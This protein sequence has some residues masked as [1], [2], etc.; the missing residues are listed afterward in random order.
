MVQ[1]N[2]FAISREFTDTVLGNF[3][4]FYEQ[5]LYKGIDKKD[6]IGLRVRP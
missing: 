3:N 5:V 6:A 4:K 1:N 2:S